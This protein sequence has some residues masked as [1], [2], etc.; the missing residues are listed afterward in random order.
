MF[1]SSDDITSKG[2][3]KFFFKNLRE[4]VGQR[5]ESCV[6]F[7]FAK[8]YAEILK[9]FQLLVDS[10]EERRREVI[11]VVHIIGGIVKI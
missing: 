8:D 2:K 5:K 1:M 3:R 6:E 9:W 11:V 7:D 10:L 4:Q